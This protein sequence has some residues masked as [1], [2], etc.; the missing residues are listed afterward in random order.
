MSNFNNLLKN[1]TCKTSSNRDQMVIII[2][3]IQLSDVKGII[4]NIFN[5]IYIDLFFLNPGICC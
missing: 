1:E 5:A 4:K 3:T 2:I